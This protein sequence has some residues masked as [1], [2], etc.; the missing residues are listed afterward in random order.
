MITID[1][2]RTLLAA[3]NGGLTAVTDANVQVIDSPDIME[4]LEELC[5]HKN[6]PFA[7]LF[8]EAFTYDD[9]DR[10]DVPVT[11]YRQCIYVMRMC[12]ADET[13]RSQELL[14]FDDIKHIRALLLTRQFEGDTELKDWTRTCRRDF[15]SGASNYVGW[16][17]SLNFVENE[18]WSLTKW[19]TTTAQEEAPTISE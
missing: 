3:E 7:V 4:G 1:Y 6:L 12:A 8:E 10:N 13:K 14:C 11:R 2:L 5:Q 18:D 17:L 15:V 16:K 19:Q 9:D